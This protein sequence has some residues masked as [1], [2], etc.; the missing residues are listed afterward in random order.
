MRVNSTPPC[1]VTQVFIAYRAAQRTPA[2][3]LLII[4]ACSL[5]STPSFS[6]ARRRLPWPPFL[7]C[8]HCQDMPPQH[9]KSSTPDAPN[10]FARLHQHGI[11]RVRVVGGAEW[12]PRVIRAG[13]RKCHHHC[14][15][16]RRSVSCYDGQCVL[17][18]IELLGICRVYSRA[19]AK[20]PRL[21]WI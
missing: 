21:V 9:A 1:H 3:Q 4:A 16:L 18:R 7:G 10:M 5:D 15:I 6:L 2:C 19:A 8:H 17:A 14:H 12:C 13:M 20:A 11:G